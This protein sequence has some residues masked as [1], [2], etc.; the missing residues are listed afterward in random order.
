[1]K[2]A[3]NYKLGRGDWFQNGSLCVDRNGSDPNP[4]N[5]GS[6]FSHNVK[7]VTIPTA[8]MRSGW[9]QGQMHLFEFLD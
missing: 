2:Y 4:E 9:G 5:L 7:P 8:M 6:T 3:F 1:M